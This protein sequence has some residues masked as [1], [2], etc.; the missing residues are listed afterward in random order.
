MDRCSMK[1]RK[2]C[3]KLIRLI[4]TAQQEFSS[5]GTTLPLVL[6][7]YCIQFALTFISTPSLLYGAE[8]MLVKNMA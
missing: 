5:A 3:M 8:L 4:K 6:I 2:T 1:A 7:K